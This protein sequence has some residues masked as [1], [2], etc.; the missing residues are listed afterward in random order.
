M[1]ILRVAMNRG[2][3]R[4]TAHELGTALVFAPPATM[5][6][7]QSQTQVGHTTICETEDTTSP[8]RP[9]TSTT[10]GVK[11]TGVSS[12]LWSMHNGYV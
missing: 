7:E 8:N 1:I 9:D 5:I 4:E 3:L 2:W 6:H 10:K 12:L 11:A